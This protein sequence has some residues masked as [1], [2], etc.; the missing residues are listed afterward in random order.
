[1]DNVKINE[2]ITN[3]AQRVLVSE[4]QDKLRSDE[5]DL[6]SIGDYT[7]AI[8]YALLRTCLDFYSLNL[9]N[10]SLKNGVSKFNLLYRK[11]IEKIFYS[12]N[13]DELTIKVDESSF[14][15]ISDN[16]KFI[17]YSIR[18]LST[19]YDGFSIVHTINII[20]KYPEIT[21]NINL[22]YVSYKKYFKE[23]ISDFNIRT[24]MLDIILQNT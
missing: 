12:E 7:D 3:Y 16:T 2:T 13:L 14:S 6:Y 20:S 9:K 24:N 19:Y 18:N 15:N 10:I 22:N 17:L 11:N 8:S 21:R 1:M 5:L 4:V 23:D